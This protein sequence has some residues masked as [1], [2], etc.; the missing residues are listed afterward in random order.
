[1]SLPPGPPGRSDG[2]SISPF[3]RDG[4]LTEGG[5]PTLVRVAGAAAEVLVTLYWPASDG[6]T[7]PSLRLTRWADE[8]ARRPSGTTAVSPP[9]EVP[10]IIVHI[11]GIGDVGGRI[12]AWIG[13]RGGGGAI[14]GFGL[15]PRHGISHEDFAVRAILG[16]DWV[17]PWLPGGQFCGSRGLALPLRGFGLRLGPPAA[18]RHDFQVVARF[19]DGTEVAAE[20]AEVVCASPD[21]AP[22]EAFRV[23]IR[24]K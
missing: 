11:G 13:T 9:R 5:E 4:W 8:A 19:I 3:R 24:A 17:S 2:I 12:G 10:E 22:L 6:F 14:E 16:R 7:A 18:M 15:T 23:R 1:V 21:M 20:G